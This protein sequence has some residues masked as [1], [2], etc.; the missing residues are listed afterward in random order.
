MRQTTLDA[1]N[2]GIAEVINKHL[3]D[4][5]LD[6]ATHTQD[7]GEFKTHANDNDARAT[8]TKP[9]DIQQVP[10]PN[11]NI[12]LHVMVPT[13]SARSH[14]PSPSTPTRRKSDAKALSGTH[15]EIHVEPG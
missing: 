13:N 9:E 2:K 6:T 4:K 15:I 12:Q 5:S 8:L 3:A 10:S 1:A 11:R 14:S 7:N